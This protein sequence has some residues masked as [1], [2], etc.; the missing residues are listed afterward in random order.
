M[1]PLR[2]TE[3]D[4]PI[5]P[6][7]KFHRETGMLLVQRGGIILQRDD[8]GRWRLVCD[9]DVESLLGSRVTV[10]GVRAGFDVIDVSRIR[11]C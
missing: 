7:G 5:M 4:V 1:G 11:K 10:E 3:P 2:P 6:V 9:E 8:G